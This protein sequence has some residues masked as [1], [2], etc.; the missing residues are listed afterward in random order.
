M[1]I[2]RL[3]DDASGLP[4]CCIG[5]H[6]RRRQSRMLLLAARPPW[7]LLI[8]ASIP[9]FPISLPF[10]QQPG[11]LAVLS[12]FPCLLVRYRRVFPLLRSPFPN[13]LRT[14]SLLFHQSWDAGRLRDHLVLRRTDTYDH[15]LIPPNDTCNVSSCASSSLSNPPAQPHNPSH[16][17]WDG[18]SGMGNF[19]GLGN[20][21]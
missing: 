16:E 3:Q 13:I 7:V 6:A 19:F 12:R 11:L 8:E 5:R 4:P 10:L 2:G 15:R 18:H 1:Q 9:P 21:R 20:A 17:G 14:S